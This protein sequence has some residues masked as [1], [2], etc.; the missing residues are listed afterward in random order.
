MDSK[1]TNPMNNLCFIITMLF[2][3]YVFYLVDA[4]SSLASLFRLVLRLAR[5]ARQSPYPFGLGSAVALVVAVLV[6][7]LAVAVLAVAAV[8]VGLASVDLG[9]AVGS[10]AAVA[11]RAR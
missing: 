8:V 3:R 4:A 10:V 5:S 11:V 7:A 2:L 9:F 6:A 1:I